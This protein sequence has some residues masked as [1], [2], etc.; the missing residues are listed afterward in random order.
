V[1]LT[2]SYRFEYLKF[3]ATTL[4][5]FW[6]SYTNGVGSYLFAGDLNGDL[7]TNNDLLYIPRNTSEMNF[8]TIPAAGTVRSFTPAEQAAAWDAY[9]NQDPYLSQHRGEYAGRNAARL[10]MVSR[11]DFS[12]AQDLFKNI[13]SGR[14][15]LTL[16]ADFLNFSNLLNHDWG[17]GQ[18][19]F[20]QTTAGRNQPLTN[21]GVDANGAAR[22][23]LRVVNGELLNKTFESTA[24][25]AD[26]YQI[27]F[28][29]RYSFN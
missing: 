17:V 19:F 29:L 23:R 12:L 27:Q 28:S 13:G 16:R 1:F 21:T 22:Y 18:R 24:G 14:H 26:V 25:L 2:G 9:I 4:S 8:E 7:G 5:F 11:L 15:S 6:Q 10:P 3:G 20:G